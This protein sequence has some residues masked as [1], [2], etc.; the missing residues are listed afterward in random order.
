MFTGRGSP[1]EGV[2]FQGHPTL[3]YPSSDLAGQGLGVWII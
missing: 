2:I 1:T 3:R